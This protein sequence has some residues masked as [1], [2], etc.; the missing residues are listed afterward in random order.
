[1]WT[2]TASEAEEAGGA[3][4]SWLDG[5]LGIEKFPVATGETPEICVT[6]EKWVAEAVLETDCVMLVLIIQDLFCTVVKG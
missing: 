4:L 3:D 1:M 6:A 2:L 5:T